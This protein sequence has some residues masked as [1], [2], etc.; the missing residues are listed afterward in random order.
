[1]VAFIL[2]ALMNLYEARAKIA[3]R[4]FFAR[5]G[6]PMYR[7]LWTAVAVMSGGMALAQP[8]AAPPERTG[9]PNMFAATPFAPDNVIL[10]RDRNGDPAHADISG[11]WSPR[12]GGIQRFDF[13]KTKIPLTPAYTAKLNSYRALVDAGK[14]PAD[15]I[16]DCVA[17][18]VRYLTNTIEIFQLP[19]YVIMVN[20]NM[21]NVRHIYLDGKGHSSNQ[22]PTFNGDSIGHWEGDALVIESSNFRAGN[23]DQY[24]IP[25]SDKLTT[26]ERI[27]RTAPNRLQVQLTYTDPD[28]YT[29]PWSVAWEYWLQAPGRAARGEFLRKQPQPRERRRTAAGQIVTLFSFKRSCLVAAAFALA[30]AVPS[31][32][33]AHHSYAM[34][35][36][37]K[38]LTIEGTVKEFQWTNPHVWLEILA[39]KGAVGGEWHFEGG[40]VAQLKRIG[41]GRDSLKPGDKITV[42]IHPLKDGTMGGALMWVT[43]PNGTTLQGG[44]TVAQSTVPDVVEH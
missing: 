36:G 28:A 33:S 34:F 6:T 8:V 32:S 14:P 19:G 20:A 31:V 41:W 11:L 15:S 21:W 38:T 24:G 9:I 35:D 23:L 7:S 3:G 17:M 5:V 22:E 10:P 1:M 37:T 13:T 42:V 2:S 30:S 4:F 16:T 12:G 25:H 27:R 43:L 18:G 29:H 39:S 40:P 26:T 44:G